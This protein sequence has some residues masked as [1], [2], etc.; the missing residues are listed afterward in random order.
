[1]KKLFVLLMVFIFMIQ[2]QNK[3]STFKYYAKPEDAGFSSERLKRIDNFMNDAISK[4]ILPHSQAII[5]RHGRIV[6]FKSFGKKSFSKNEDLKNSDIFRLASQTKAVTTVAFM[7]LFE[8][9]KVNLNDPV[10][11]FIPGFKD[12]KV[13]KDPNGGYGENNLE[14]CQTEI[15]I[16]HLLNHTSGIPYWYD[17]KVFT[18]L[19]SPGITFNDVSLETVV[20]EM[21][22]M[23]LLHQPEKA[24]TYGYNLDVLGYIIEKVSGMSLNDFFAKKIFQPLGMKDTYFYLPQEKENRLVTLFDRE[25]VNSPVT[26]SKDDLFCNFPVKGAKKFYSGGAGLVGT[27]EDYAKFCQMLLN[28]GSFNKVQIISP[29]T[30]ELLT[31]NQVDDLPLWDT[32]NRFGYGFEIMTDKG[33]QNLLGSSGSY[34]WGGAYGTEYVI[35][36]KEDMFIIFYSNVRPFADKTEILNKYRVLAYQALI[37]SSK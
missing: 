19:T 17:S 21:A 24:L 7:I 18:S 12:V 16:R 15:T 1:M 28:N 13:M 31:R 11:H 30:I 10:W 36:P 20:T 26:E 5:V 33:L 35:D 9:G 25:T 8:E 3:N 32:G 14:K 34:K 29:K 23:P 27:I 6:Y 2:A 37:D 22:K 4:K